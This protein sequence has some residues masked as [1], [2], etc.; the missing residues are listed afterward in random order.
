MNELSERIK[1]KARDLGFDAVGIAP[2]AFLDIA[3]RAIR[4]RVASGLPCNYGFSHKPA[5]AM[6]C[7]EKLL[8]G[9]KSVIA[10][11]FSYLAPEP[12]SA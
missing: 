3:E 10:V 7:P 12:K 1:D 2:A 4:E 5:G 8:P 6:T 11:A 9:V